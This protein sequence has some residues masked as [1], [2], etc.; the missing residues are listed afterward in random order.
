[1]IVANLFVI[2][3]LLIL[4]GLVSWKIIKDRRNGIGSCGHSCS[5][6]SSHGGCQCHVDP[7]HEKELQEI[8]VRVKAKQENRSGI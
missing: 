6:C 2:V 7:K 1:M 4:A 8:L 5:S 3:C